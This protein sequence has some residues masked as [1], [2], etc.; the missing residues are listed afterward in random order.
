[1]KSK[2]V[3]VLKAPFR[4]LRAL[5]RLLGR[6]AAGF[7]RLGDKPKIAVVVVLA[8]V[9]VA[10]VLVLKPSGGDDG[11]DVRD[12]LGRFAEATREKDYQTLCDELF[13]KA[14]VETIR[15]VGLPCE[16]ALKTGL[17]SRE[18]PQLQVLGVEVKGDQAFANTRSTA[19]G[20]QPAT[21]VLRLVREDGSWRVA[22]APSGR[23]EGGA[24]AP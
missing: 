12:T 7:G 6:A 10:A 14:L 9:A 1:M 18:N 22:S 20:E 17:D 8:V 21:E 4:L 23:S 24:A 13:A 3:A 2:V 5:L 11:Q 16:V 19:V 15:S